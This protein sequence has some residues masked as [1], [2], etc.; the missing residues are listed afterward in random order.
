MIPRF[1][2]ETAEE[3][4]SKNTGD[5]IFALICFV[6]STIICIWLMKKVCRW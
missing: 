5:I 3:L 2:S 4:A 6:V 1:F